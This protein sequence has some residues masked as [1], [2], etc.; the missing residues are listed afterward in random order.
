MYY[1][2]ILKQN[3]ISADTLHHNTDLYCKNTAFLSYDTV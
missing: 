1:N 2:I 3:T